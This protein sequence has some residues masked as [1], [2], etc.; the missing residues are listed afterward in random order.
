MNTL[1]GG[2]IY[3]KLANSKDL[4]GCVTVKKQRIKKFIWR[5]EN[6]EYIFAAVLYNIA[7]QERQRDMAR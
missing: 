5:I 6:L 2:A 7:Y 3:S 4:K 1:D